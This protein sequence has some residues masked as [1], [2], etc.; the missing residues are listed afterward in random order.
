MC[1]KENLQ[2]EFDVHERKPSKGVWWKQTFKKGLMCIKANWKSQKLFPLV[3][4]VEKKLALIT[5]N[6]VLR[7]LLL[8]K[9]LS[10]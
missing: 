4:R 8:L 6:L 10:K 5:L 7:R 3:K 9:Q 2:K 1:M